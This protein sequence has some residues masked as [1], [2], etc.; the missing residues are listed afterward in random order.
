MKAWKGAILAAIIFFSTNLVRYNLGFR[1]D[2]YITGSL[3]FVLTIG[4]IKIFKVKEPKKFCIYQA[5]GLVGL[6]IFGTFMDW[7]LTDEPYELVPYILFAP[8]FAYYFYGILLGYC[9]VAFPKKR[10]LTTILFLLPMPVY[11]KYSPYIFRHEN[12]GTYTSNVNEPLPM[13]LVV[14]DEAGQA[15]KIETKNG[16]YLILD[17]WFSKCAPCFKA[18]PELEKL[19]EA[20]KDNIDIMCVNHPVKEDARENYS[21]FKSLHDKGY[22]FPVFKADT[23]VAKKLNIQT[24]PTILLIKDNKIIFR[25]NIEDLNDRYKFY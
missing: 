12:Y 10:V 9:F 4:V 14:E 13:G 17:L 23:S 22:T 11:W 19:Y 6:Y 3:F 7:L 25:G 21:P 5:I 24:F 2:F 16:R 8:N 20:Q 18:F 1:E 15:H